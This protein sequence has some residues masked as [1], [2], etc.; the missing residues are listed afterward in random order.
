MI[1]NKTV[2][3]AA[4]RAVA[5]D[6]V[7]RLVLRVKSKNFDIGSTASW[8]RHRLDYLG[9]TFVK[10]GQIASSRKDI[11][12]EDIAKG[13]RGLQDNARPIDPEDVDKLIEKIREKTKGV[14]AEIQRDPIATASI[15]QIHRGKLADGKEIV[16]KLRRPNITDDIAGDLSFLKSIA[17]FL[18]FFKVPDS[19]G[20]DNILKD[21]EQSMQQESNFLNETKN[22]I[23][24]GRIY[25][26]S[27]HYHKEP[28]V[29]PRVY[30]ELTTEEWI[31][32]DYIENAGTVFLS[33]QQARDFVR[34]LMTIFIKQLMEHGIIHGDPHPGNIGKL[35]DGRVILYDCGN[36]VYLDDKERFLIKELVYL[37]IAKN[38]YAVARVLPSLGVKVLDKEKLHEYIDKYVEYLETI[39]YKTLAEM[40]DPNTSLPVKFEG[41]LLRIIKAFGL[42]E[43]I[44][45]DLD[46]T[47]NYFQL[48]DVYVTETLLDE[49]FL[50]YKINQDMRRLQAW[51]TSFFSRFDMEI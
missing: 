3:Q 19:E 32:M 16:I 9:P 23:D 7:V 17:S 29:V 43:G 13:L 40:Y 12:G 44:C 8:L 2:R 27:D 33:P 49:D 18:T 46:P 1:H 15:G 42:L 4:K 34:N 45:K 26:K 31:V 38:K 21:V 48:M 39:D 10:L 47:F 37:L 36:V 6:T 30:A 11:V 5:V 41:K 20:L 24:L 50:V 25:T 35:A 51:P 14:V 28:V 22:L